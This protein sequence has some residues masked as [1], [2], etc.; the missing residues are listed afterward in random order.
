MNKNPKG[1]KACLPLPVCA[2]R[3]VFWGSLLL[4]SS[5]GLPSHLGLS[6]KQAQH[7][8]LLLVQRRHARCT[9]LCVRNILP[10]SLLE[11]QPAPP[12]AAAPAAVLP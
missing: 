8:L 3:P 7:H 2:V 11:G 6:A 9:S 1:A 12:R 10:V 4:Q 5:Q